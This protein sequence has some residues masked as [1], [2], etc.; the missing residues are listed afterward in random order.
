MSQAEDPMAEDGAVVPPQEPRE[1]VVPAILC[2]EVAKGAP[3]S[4]EVREEILHTLTTAMRIDTNHI[5][6]CDSADSDVPKRE[7][8]TCAVIRYAGSGPCY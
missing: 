4:E 2:M 7:A 5:T 6:M 1:V 3:N 8:D